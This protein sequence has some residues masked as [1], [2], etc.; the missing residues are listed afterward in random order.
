MQFNL[1]NAYSAAIGRSP[2]EVLFGFRLNDPLHQ[3]GD[4][5]PELS[6]AI[7]REEASL[8]IAT[9]QAAMKQRYD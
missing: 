6:R 1:N 7:H 4:A 8:A 3:L 2:N 9:A 5:A